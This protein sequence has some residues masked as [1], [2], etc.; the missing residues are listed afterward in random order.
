MTFNFTFKAKIVHASSDVE[1]ASHAPMITVGISADPDFFFCLLVCLPAHNQN[2]VTQLLPCCLGR[3]TGLS[4]THAWSIWWKLESWHSLS[5]CRLIRSLILF[6]DARLVHRKV[7][8]IQIFIMTSMCHWVV[9]I[10]V[11]CSYKWPIHQKILLNIN[12]SWLTSYWWLWNFDKIAFWNSSD[13]LTS[14][15]FFT[16]VRFR[17]IIWVVLC[18]WLF[19]KVRSLCPETVDNTLSPGTCLCH[20][21]ACH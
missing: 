15:I 6:H 8:V 4:K 14:S 5:K 13:T 3:W 18:T 10:C 11:N 21:V 7:W 20:V 19:N 16:L 17:Q 2:R 12:L 1:I 9:I